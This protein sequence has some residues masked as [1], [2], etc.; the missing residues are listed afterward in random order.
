M[1]WD[2]LIRAVNKAE[3]RAKI[4]GSTYL[5]QRCPKGKQSLKMSLNARDDQA[6]KTKA[7]SP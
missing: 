2:D 1:P 3:A 6:K 4:Q 5:D 7:T